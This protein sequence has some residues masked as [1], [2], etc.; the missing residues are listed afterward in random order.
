MNLQPFLSDV[1]P[2]CVPGH[3]GHSATGIQRLG[4]RVS[5]LKQLMANLLELPCPRVQPVYRGWDVL[6]TC[7]CTGVPILLFPQPTSG[8]SGAPAAPTYT[9]QQHALLVAPLLQ[10]LPGQW[11]GIGWNGMGS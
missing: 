9:P 8:A 3:T 5:L 1:Q 4:W 10:P 6:M 11:D 7:G 2:G